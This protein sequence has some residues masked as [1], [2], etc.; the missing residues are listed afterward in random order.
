MD[1]QCGLGFS[2]HVVAGFQVGCPKSK[3][4]KR[5][6]AKIFLKAMLQTGTVSFL[7]YSIT[8]SSHRPA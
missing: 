5:R 8:P 7:P 2:L 4:L 6:E 1:P 3:C